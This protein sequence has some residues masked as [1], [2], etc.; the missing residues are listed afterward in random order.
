MIEKEIHRREYF[1]L[2]ALQEAENAFEIDEVPI[3]AVVV[4]EGKIIGKGH[5]QTEKLKDVT[6]HAEM[7]SI[8]A[9]AN[10]LGNK[11]LE[12][13]DL[14]V[15][16]EPCVMCLGAIKNARI[17][18]IFIGSKEPK[19]GFSKFVENDFYKD[20]NIEFNIKQNECSLLMKDFFAMK[21]K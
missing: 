17:K 9:A 5:N 19:T 3:G 7:I 11:Y 4:C 12:E 10:H 14:Y 8:T 1:M 2:K 20:L 15:T 18:N 13:C 21:R 16:I 6:A